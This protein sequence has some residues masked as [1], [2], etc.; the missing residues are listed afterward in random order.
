MKKVLILFGTVVFLTLGSGNSMAQLDGHGNA[1]DFT[2]TDIDGTEHHLYDYLDSGK[3]VL[4]DFFATWC[5]ICRSNTPLLEDIY[6]KY[7]PGGSG[8]MELLSLE[9]YTPTTDLEVREFMETYGSTNPHINE[10][11]GVGEMYNLSGFPYYYVV[12]PD[13]S[14]KVFAGIVM[15]LESE[16]SYAIEN[17]PGLRDVEND[18][19]I[20]GFNEPRGTYCNEDIIPE[21]EL[22]NYGKNDITQLRLNIEIDGILEYSREYTERLLPYEYATLTFPKLENLDQGWHE[23]DVSVS[24]VNSSSDAEPNNGPSSGSFLFLQQSE[25][26]IVKVIT[27]T[28]PAETFWQVTEDGKVAAER[29][30]FQIASTT[31]HDTICLEANHCYTISLHDRFGDGLSTGGLQLIYRGD[32]I[33][34]FKSDSFNSG[35]EQIEFCLSGASGI[36]VNTL[37]EYD[38]IAFPNPT[39]GEINLMFPYDFEQSSIVTLHNLAGQVFYEEQLSRGLTKKTINLSAFSNGIIFLRVSYGNQVIT[40]EILIQK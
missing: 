35:S 4:I 40:K 32:I 19:R 25:N 27:D 21:I 14:Y 33:A 11:E 26:L 24:S 17:S 3:V 38:I 1:P 23:F 15:N 5:G 36:D 12:A 39:N 37:K 30:S 16:L 34:E 18:I 2:L 28:Y 29:Q 22:Q 6:N 7:G 10:T 20:I 9:A 13:R 8:V 31:Y